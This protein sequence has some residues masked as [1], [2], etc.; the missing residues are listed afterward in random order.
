MIIC[1]A[2]CQK[3]VGGSFVSRLASE[4]A[5]CMHSNKDGDGSGGGLNPRCL[6]MRQEIAGLQVHD[7]VVRMSKKGQSSRRGS[8]NVDST[9]STG[10]DPPD[11]GAHC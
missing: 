10:Q 11:A 4:I 5:C 3:A 7:G 6:A 1:L 8:R 2:F 9:E